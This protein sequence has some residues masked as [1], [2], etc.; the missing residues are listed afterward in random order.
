MKKIIL[1]EENC[2]GP[3][4]GI[5][6]ALKELSKLKNKKDYFI[7]G[8]LGHNKFLCNYL[9]KKGI[10]SIINIRDKKT[11]KIVIR[12]HGINKKDF[13]FLRE[14]KIPYKD[15]SCIFVKKL[16]R[17]ALNAEKKGYKIII[18]G[19]KKHIEIQNVCSFLKN[20][21][22]LEEKKELD[23]IP[24]FS[25]VAVFTQTT[26]TKNKINSLLPQ[27]KRKYKDLIYIETRCPET[28]K[29]QNQALEIAKNVDVM[30]IIGN[31]ISKNANNLFDICKP[32]TKT[33][34]IEKPSDLKKI[35]LKNIMN[36]GIIASA[37]TPSFVTKEVLRILNKKIL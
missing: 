21:I 19:N 25:K 35:A 27:L 22:V 29:R 33:F 28:E 32:K 3:C 20:S 9:E 26:Q 7:Y 1:P 23:K 30:F 18:L 34:L 6:R 36:I 14:N 2:L 8:E 12:S 15:L 4:F 11:K 10:K 13:Q 24:S 16:L 37:S 31:K 17:E 5:K